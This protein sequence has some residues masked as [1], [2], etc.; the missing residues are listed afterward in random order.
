MVAQKKKQIISDW[1]EMVSINVVWIWWHSG[2][3][4]PVFG[5]SKA[6]YSF[7]TCWKSGKQRFSY[8][9]RWYRRSKSSYSLQIPE[10]KDQKNYDFWNFYRRYD[11]LV[12]IWEKKM[13]S[14]VWKYNLWKLSFLN[15]V[16]SVLG[17]IPFNF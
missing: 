11:E 10:N 9:F 16:K 7:Y 12:W 14:L 4:F 3:H 15:E 8:V 13:L 5:V 17:M 6:I 1:N 2:R